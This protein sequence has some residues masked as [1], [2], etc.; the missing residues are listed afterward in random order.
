[1]VPA[2]CQDGDP[3]KHERYNLIGETSHGSHT[4]NENPGRTWNLCFRSSVEA[5]LYMVL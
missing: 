1:M 2:D 4:V 3:G 5:I